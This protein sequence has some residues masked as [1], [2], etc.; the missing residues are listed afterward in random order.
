MS[1][2]FKIGNKDFTNFITVPGYTVNSKDIYEEYS[3]GD[4]KFHRRPI[5]TRVSGSFQLS[6]SDKD[7]YIDFLTTV[8][9]SKTSEGTI[10]AT[11]YVNDLMETKTSVFF[12]EMEPANI[13]PF[14]GIKKTDGLEITLEEQ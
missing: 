3:D 12:I 10:N 11:V 9:N 1:A 7:D 5:R 6:F 2:L 8:K 4:H 13:I 14:L